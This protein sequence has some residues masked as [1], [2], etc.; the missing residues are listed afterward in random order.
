MFVLSGGMTGCD[1][2]ENLSSVKDV[3]TRLAWDSL[4]DHKELAFDN[5]NNKNMRFHF[6]ERKEMM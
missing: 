3:T 2:K 5:M 1:D 6:V 4:K